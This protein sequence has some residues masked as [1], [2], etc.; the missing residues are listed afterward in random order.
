MMELKKFIPLSIKKFVIEKIQ[1]NEINKEKSDFIKYLNSINYKNKVWILDACDHYNLGDQAILM[2]ELDFLKDNFKEYE[3]ISVGLNKYDRYICDIKRIV[4]TNDI[5]FL[6]GGGNF[7]NYYRNAERIRRNIIETF[8]SNKIVLFPQTIYFSND[9]EGKKELKKSID[10][11]SQHKELI[12]VAREKIS[13]DLMKMNFLNNK[14]L[15]TPDIVLYL[16]KSK[17]DDHRNG[18]LMCCRND[19]EGMLTEQNKNYLVDILKKNFKSIKITDTVGGN[20]FND[21]ENKLNEFIKS[22]LVITDRIHGMI[23]AAIT[24]TPCI[25]LSNYNYKVKGTYEWIKNLGY[26][27]FVENIEE[28]PKFIDDI[29]KIEDIKYNNSE[30]KVKYEEIVKAINDRI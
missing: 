18:A 15:L 5:I 24:G 7:G 10:I 9:E 2:A 25:A 23:F 11:Y 17:N 6:H 3:I 8:P 27:K 4:K 14:V 22:E 28:I 12:L 13:Y 16:N 19:I 20:T 26:I 1:Q 30:F 29:R 21:V